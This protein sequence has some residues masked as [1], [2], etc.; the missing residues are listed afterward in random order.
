MSDCETSY[1]ALYSKYLKAVNSSVLC[2]IEIPRKPTRGAHNDI[3]CEW[4]AHPD[5]RMV[6]RYWDRPCYHMGTINCLKHPNSVKI[7][8]HVDQKSDVPAV[9]P[10][11]FVLILFCLRG[12]DRGY[13]V[14]R[15]TMGRIMRLRLEAQRLY[16]P[17][18]PVRLD[19]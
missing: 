11:D 4:I 9:P 2:T 15:K 7:H 8:A 18:P 6:L 12:I 14:L 1:E 13:S 5:T 3:L 19:R 16:I 10:Q 17:L